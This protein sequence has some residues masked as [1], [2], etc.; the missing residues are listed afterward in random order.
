[1]GS[2]EISVECFGVHLISTISV[3]C[4]VRLD[5]G[6]EPTGFLMRKSG[7]SWYTQESPDK[8]LF[9]EDTVTMLALP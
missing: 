3:S 9:G 4:V 6:S 2:V 7:I 5:I 1:M 8:T